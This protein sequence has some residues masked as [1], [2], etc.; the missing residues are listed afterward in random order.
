MKNTR[1]FI[2]FLLLLAVLLGLCACG[3]SEIVPEGQLDATV[4]G[5]G[6]AD[7]FEYDVYS[8]GTVGITKYTGGYTRHTVPTEIDGMQVSRICDRAYFDCGLVKVTIPD[9]V[10]FIG[11][12]AFEQN[13]EL[14][15]VNMSQNCKYIG[16]KGFYNCKKLKSIDIPDGL[17]SIGP[18]AFTL[19]RWLNS[20]K[21]D[22]VI[23]GQGILI[24]YHGHESEVTIPP[25]VRMISTAFTA[26]N[27]RDT[28]IR[29]GFDKVVI[30]DSVEIIGDCAFNLCTHLSEVVI[31]DSVTYIGERA[32]GDCISITELEIPE[33]VKRIE[34]Y[35]F[36]ACEGL[37]EYTVPDHIEYVGYMA[38]GKCLNLE[39]LTIGSGASYIDPFV[40]N[41]SDILAELCVSEDNEY[42]TASDLCIYNKDMTQL[43]Y[44]HKYK[45]DTLVTIPDTVR[46]I[47]RKALYGAENIVEIYFPAELETIRL[48]AFDGCSSIEYIH[49]GDKLRL[50]E[51]SAFLNC[52][53]FSE[54]FYSGTREQ[55]DEIEIGENN[56]SFLATYV[57]Y[58]WTEE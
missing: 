19:T 42:Y 18:Y 30:G 36:Y 23:V 52:P 53:S 8:D 48:G 25:E 54:I 6:V 20:R 29:T 2:S 28:G 17:E 7:G 45:P 51:N 26:L 58:E 3:Q 56:L 24:R 44:Y 49:I 50:I 33:S 46:E 11:E 39:K 14:L 5:S 41:E 38:F 1:R 37:K 35:T 21:E 47:G 22:F 13:Q 12:S 31:P 57:N 43:L 34:D 9:S 27:G 4:T 55:W 15:K 16:T 32:F 40:V 10:I